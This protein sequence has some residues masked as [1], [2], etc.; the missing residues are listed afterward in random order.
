MMKIKV[1]TCTVFMF[2]S[3]I[4]LYICVLKFLSEILALGFDKKFIK[5][6]EYYFIYCAAGFKSL[7]AGDYQVCIRT[8][9]LEE[10]EDEEINISRI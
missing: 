9:A 7:T 6:W 10:K 5:T 3:L 1:S 4:S 2:H 8:D